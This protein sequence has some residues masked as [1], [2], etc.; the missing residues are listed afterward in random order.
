MSDGLALR[1]CEV[2]HFSFIDFLVIL[3][4]I[5]STLRF[6]KVFTYF[7]GPFFAEQSVSA[8]LVFD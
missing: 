2:N 4:F 8:D 3:G 7:A 5:A 6:D 1:T